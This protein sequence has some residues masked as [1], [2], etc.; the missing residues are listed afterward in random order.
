MTATP[1]TP[2][3]ACDSPDAFPDE[4]QPVKPAPVSSAESAK[5][6]GRSVFEDLYFDWQV[7]DE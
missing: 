5:F 1:S 4:N 2:K 6:T 3:P 7:K